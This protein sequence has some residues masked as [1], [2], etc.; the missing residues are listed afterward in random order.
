M[1]QINNT[2]YNIIHFIQLRRRHDARFFYFFSTCRPFN[3]YQPIRTVQCLVIFYEVLK[4]VEPN[5]SGDQAY[6]H[7]HVVS[8]DEYFA[9]SAG[10]FARL[11][12]RS[13]ITI[14]TGIEKINN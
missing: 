5:E 13:Q 1:L 2:F 8:V 3:V 7:C 10:R 4:H 14:E 11:G 6:D 9:R 12:K